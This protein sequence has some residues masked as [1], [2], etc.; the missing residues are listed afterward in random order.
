M[1]RSAS[2][3]AQH[4]P[5]SI[6][7]SSLPM[8]AG[9]RP[10]PASWG[11]RLEDRQFLNMVRA[12]RA[13]GGLANGDEV[14]RLLR[15]RSEQPISMLARW[16]VDRSVVSIVWQ[17]QTLLPLFQFDLADMSLRS[18][19][20]AVIRELVDAFDDWEIA[21]WFAQ[22]NTWL[23]GAAPVDN[24]ASDQSAVLSAARAD[25]FIALG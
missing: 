18:G 21:H 16:I 7:K 24:M 4:A 25:R 1:D 19:T 12:Y 20:S 17:S 6:A 3:H 22:P 11:H 9:V 8:P 15:K 2:S 5:A 23:D 14:A 13:T 10:L